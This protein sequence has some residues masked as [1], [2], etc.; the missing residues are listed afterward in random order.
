MRSVADG[1]HARG[2]PPPEAFAARRGKLR[3]A[4]SAASEC[5]T[6][7][8][9]VRSNLARNQPFFALLVMS[10]TIALAAFCISWAVAEAA[11]CA[12]WLTSVICC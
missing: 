7:G 2:C 3:S 9:P 5:R 12:T 4:A 8:L 11:F 1:C 6:D 10:W